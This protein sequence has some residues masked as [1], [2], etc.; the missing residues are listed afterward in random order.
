[1]SA[2]IPAALLLGA[3]IYAAQVS[4]YALMT[5]SFP[6]HVRA[7]GVGFVTG[8][9]R[10]GGISSPLVSGYLLGTGLRYSQVSGLMALGSLLG[11]VVLLASMRL[12]QP[13]PP[14]AVA[15]GSRPGRQ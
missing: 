8:V 9:G 1:M 2:L 15:S 6:V 13:V 4:L 12:A 10:L 5:R 3:F 14:P 7:T 11:A